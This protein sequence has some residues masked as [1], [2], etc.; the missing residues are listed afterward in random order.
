MGIE[1]AEQAASI[2]VA[3]IDGD[4]VGQVKEGSEGTKAYE[5]TRSA[6]Q[7]M[8]E[9]TDIKYLYTLYTDGSNVL[10]GVDAAEEDPEVV[11]SK[12]EE[13]Y[14]TLQSIFEEGKQW[15]QD[16]IDDSNLITVYM[17]IKDSQGNVVAALGCDYDASSI[18]ERVLT[19]VER[20]VLIGIICLIIAIF[21]MNVIVRRIL[22]GL[23]A[24]DDK[25]YDL[26]NNEGD[27]TQ[28]LDVTSGDEL[29]LIANN[30]NSLLKYIREIMLNIS[31]NSISLKEAAQTMVENVR[32]ADDNIID[33]S[34]NMEEMSAAMEE[35]TASLN[36][37]ATS[38]NDIFVSVEEMASHA[39]E[40]NDYTMEMDSRS[41]QAREDALAKQK[42]AVE[43][44]EK[45]ANE[46]HQ[47]IEQSKAVE[48]ISVLTN[49]IIS[50]TDQTNLLALNAS[51]EA[52]RAGEAG[53][54]FA[55][56][57]GEIGQL[58]NDSASAAE[59]IR[60]V[61]A[62]VIDAVNAL[63]KEAERMIEFASETAVGGYDG[64]VE[65]SES[66]HTDANTMNE[67]MES[68]AQTSAQLQE[69]MD[70][71]KVSVGDV[72]LAVEESARG[73]SNVSE[74][75]VQLTGSVGNIQ[76]QA[77]GNSDVAKQLSEEVGKF[78]L[79]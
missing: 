39:K 15:N 68:F 76:E 14:A 6:M 77:S 61:S 42:E 63:A 53:K 26:V 55:V 27:L 49:N 4:L 22:K 67:I 25:I 60:K 33:V 50:I 72:N 34:A 47:R 28:T 41:A 12:F 45:I 66:Y 19:S 5:Q 48:E 79:E 74:M 71:I 52:A 8:I 44:T 70:S 1:E 18:R 23:H 2:T 21:I 10:Y 32:S 46:L 51:I 57:A 36:Q 75:S 17:P 62:G 9:S 13:E 30:V 24:I 20:T 73:I 3:Q 29:E 69:T 38:I 56:V 37:I 11:G 59:Q 78:K 58:A 31:A 65:L 54:G 7:K 35:T 40:G 64:M 43:E 16:Y